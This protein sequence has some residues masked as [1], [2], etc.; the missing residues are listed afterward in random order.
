[1][2]KENYT[3]LIC[4]DDPS[5]CE[6][7]EGA[8][9]EYADLYHI[10][11]KTEVFYT[12][13]RLYEYIKCHNGIDLLFLDI[14]LPGINGAGVGN[15]LREALGNNSVQIVYISAS[16]TYVLGLFRARPFDF[17]VKPV[18]KEMLIDVFERYMEIYSGKKGYF[19]YKTGKSS[20]KIFLSD[21]MYFV[22]EGR[23][24]NIVTKYG[25]VSFYGRI[26]DI[27][28]KYEK[29]GFW[30]IHNSYIIN[31]AYAKEFKKDKILMCDDT[32]IPI[33]KTYKRDVN[34]KMF[35]LLR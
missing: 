34:H 4:D 5:E 28:G 25:V 10:C 15:L 1:M 2:E 29:D 7:L 14:N 18:K 26:K 22:S 23:K 11:I 8:F 35:G 17:L 13:E 16:T 24:I 32:E 19:E 21:I 12:G 20:N 33:S 27:H 6:F 31:I 9:A 30:T 3:I